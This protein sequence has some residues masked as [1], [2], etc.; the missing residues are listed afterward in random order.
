MSLN[1]K[2]R[3]GKSGEKAVALRY[4]T[5]E[6]LPS[7]IAKGRGGAAGKILELAEKHGIPIQE[8]SALVALLE[9]TPVEGSIPD[10]SFALV[11]ELLCFLYEIDKKFRERHPFL[12][13][14]LPGGGIL[15]SP[16]AGGKC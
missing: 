2:Q 6:E 1:S 15:A 9:Q 8:D 13:N 7:V 12:G 14:P 10:E 11:A 4:N 5:P 16:S 3:E